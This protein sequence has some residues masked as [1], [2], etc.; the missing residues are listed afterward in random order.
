MHFSAEVAGALDDVRARFP[1]EY[2]RYCGAFQ[3]A[4]DDAALKERVALINPLN[5]I[6]AG[7]QSRRAGHYRIRVG[8]SDADTSLSVSLVLALKLANAG[9]GSVDYAMVWDQPHCEAD[10]PG[11]ILSWI[12]R[13]SR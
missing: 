11:E 3:A 7:M 1:A 8:A 12:D 6:G 4:R 2:A 13:V 9:Y 10:Y 5:Y